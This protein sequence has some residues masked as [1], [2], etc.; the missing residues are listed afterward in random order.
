MGARD[1][2]S[3]RRETRLAGADRTAVLMNW[4]S[5]IRK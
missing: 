3:E 2:P 4:Q 1:Q 5:A